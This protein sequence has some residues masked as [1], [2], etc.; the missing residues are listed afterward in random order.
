MDVTRSGRVYRFR[1]DPMKR[2]R[3]ELLT[4]VLTFVF[5]PDNSDGRKAMTILLVIVWAAIEVGAA[6][7]F[8]TLPDQ[9]FFLRLVVGIMIGRMWGIEINNFAGLE[10][11]YESTGTGE[12]HGDD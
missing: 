11:D 10:F 6:F 1:D 9:F 5:H 3:A 8:A 4:F 7:G 12:D 2:L